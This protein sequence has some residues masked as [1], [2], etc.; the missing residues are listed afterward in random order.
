MTDPSTTLA[1]FDPIA[2]TI[3]EYKIENANLNFNLEDKQDNKDARS[4]VSKLRKAKTAIAVIHKGAKADA[5]AFGRRLDAKKNELTAATDE[6][7]DVWWPKIK[8]IEQR[9]FKKMADEAEARRL[10]IEAEEAERLADIE[11]REVAMAEKEREAKEE[12]DRIAREQ[13]EK[14]AAEN[15]ILR[16]RQALL[17]ED[18]R[19]LEAEAEAVRRAKEAAEQ[20]KAEAEEAHREQAEAEQAERL[21]Q[22]Q[23]EAKRVAN[24]EHREKIE[25]EIAEDLCGLLDNVNASKVLTA[26]RDDKIRN[27]TILY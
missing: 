14:V 26:L 18:K 16:A 1:K 9:E 12:A 27:I 10:K 11:A 19:A 5:L 25:L 20:A 24:E 8:E 15:E 22:E 2:A 23:T 17:E 4:H 7:I 13:A 6:M 3:A 21:M